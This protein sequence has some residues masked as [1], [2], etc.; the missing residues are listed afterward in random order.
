MSG[1][2]GAFN[3]KASA[4]TY[5]SHFIAVKKGARTL[6]VLKHEFVHVCQ[7]D[8][9]GQQG[10]ADEYANQFV[11]NGYNE[12]NGALEKQ[13]YKYAA[14]PDATSPPIKAFLGYCE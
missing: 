1:M 12:Q 2:T 13:A 6:S 14:L 7:Y 9:L 8:K 5:G 3:F 10:F 4:T 11:D